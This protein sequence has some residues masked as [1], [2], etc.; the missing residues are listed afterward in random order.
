MLFLPIVCLWKKTLLPSN[1]HISTTFFHKT[2]FFSK[3]FFGKPPSNKHP[4][5]LSYCVNSFYIWKDIV[6]KKVSKLRS[7]AELRAFY[8]TIIIT[9]CTYADINGTYLLYLG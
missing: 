5:T 2:V 4:F 3:I 7:I 6:G 8:G 9:L 1:A